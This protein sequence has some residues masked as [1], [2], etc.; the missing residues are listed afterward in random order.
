[1]AKAKRKRASSGNAAVMVEPEKLQTENIPDPSLSALEGLPS[2]M[3]DPVESLMEAGL[4]KNL[5]TLGDEVEERLARKLQVLGQFYG[6]SVNAKILFEI[7][8]NNPS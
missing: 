4:R 7:T 3:P 8:V 5:Q 2:P 1:M 6:V